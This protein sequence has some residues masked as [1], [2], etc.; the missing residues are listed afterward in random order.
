MPNYSE[1]QSWWLINQIL[2]GRFSIKGKGGYPSA[3]TGELIHWQTA[4][5]WIHEKL[6]QDAA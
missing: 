6:E 1:P 2:H 4:A 5:H 3:E